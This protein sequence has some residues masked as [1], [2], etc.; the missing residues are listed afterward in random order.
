MEQ[1]ARRDPGVAVGAH[2][3]VGADA[4]ASLSGGQRQTVA[5]AKSVLWDSKVVLLDEPTAALGVAQTRQVLDL[6]RRLAEQGLGVVLIS[7]NMADVFEVVRPH[8]HALPGPDGRRGADQGR[9]PRPGRRADHRGPLRRSGP[10]A[11]GERD[12]L[13]TSTRRR[14]GAD[15]RR[16][17]PS[18]AG[19]GVRRSA[20]FGIDTTS[21]STG[22]AV[23]DYVTSLR[24]GELGSLPALLGLLALFILFTRAGA[25]TRSRACSTS[26]TCSSRAPGRPIIAMGLVFVLL[27]GEIDLAA[28]TASGLAAAVMAL[29]LVSNGNLLGAMGTTVFCCLLRASWRR[30]RAGACCCGSGSARRAAPRS[31]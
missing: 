8:R 15:G 25:A 26:P 16:A 2:G 31:R 4:V 17:P 29:H 19:A 20:D 28:G 23:R 6:V 9:H 12:R 5:I 10:A 11:S 7:H 27:I 24:G 22:E 3:D 21:K 18:T 13:M 14:P 1:A 30:G